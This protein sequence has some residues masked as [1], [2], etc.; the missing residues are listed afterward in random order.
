MKHILLFLVLSLVSVSAAVAEDPDGRTAFISAPGRDI[1]AAMK[2]AEKE[3]KRVLVFVVEPGKKAGTHIRGT[4]ETPEAKK[5]AED[6]FVV[7]F[8]T[9]R[10]EKHVAGMVDDV[11][12]VHPAYVLFKTDGT[13][14]EK[15]DAAMG[16][17]N[18]LNWLRK[19]SA[20]P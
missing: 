12:P 18:G 14:I 1:E 20:A 19:I 8:V 17:N 6:N 5:L 13:V 3:K 4:M 2:R 10:K 11:S 16:G 9:S 7:V 15:G